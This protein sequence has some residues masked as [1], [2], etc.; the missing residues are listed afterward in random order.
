MQPTIELHHAA[1]MT[2]SRERKIQRFFFSQCGRECFFRRFV[3]FVRLANRFFF[4]LVL[5]HRLVARTHASTRLTFVFVCACVWRKPRWPCDTETYFI[6]RHSQRSLSK[7]YLIYHLEK[8]PYAKL[9]RKTQTFSRVHGPLSPHSPHSP[10]FSCAVPATALRFT[11]SS[12]YSSGAQHGAF[13]SKQAFFFFF[14]HI[15]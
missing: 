15:W 4:L 13:F 1:R 11:C 12:G 9:R 5:R 2:W 14:P 3:F 6:P 10:L 8:K 7:Y